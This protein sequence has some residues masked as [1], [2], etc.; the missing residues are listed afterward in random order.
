MPEAQLALAQATD[1]SGDRTEVERGDHA[2]SARRWRRPGGQG[3]S[4]ARRTAGRPLLRGPRNSATRMAT[5]IRTTTG[6]VCAPA[7]SARRVGRRRLL[8]ADHLRGRTRDLRPAGQ[9]AGDHPQEALTANLDP[10]SRRTFSQH[11]RSRSLTPSSAQAAAALGIVYGL[12]TARLRSRW[13][14]RSCPP[15]EATPGAD[16][17]F[18][19]HVMLSRRRR[20]LSLHRANALRPRFAPRQNSA[21]EELRS[22][23]GLDVLVVAL[24][25]DRSA[26]DFEPVAVAGERRSEVARLSDRRREPCVTEI[27]LPRTT[28]DYVVARKIVT[29]LSPGVTLVEGFSCG[30]ADVG[31]NATEAAF[32]SS[33][34][35]VLLLL[36]RRWL[37][38]R[39]ALAL[40]AV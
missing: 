33:R 25:F 5:C 9:A 32:V 20:P 34:I 21:G 28:A 2:R 38:R 16:S 27:V 31:V 36:G 7:V 15:S 40:I 18:G 24:E 8:P 23:T 3:R 19:Q 6:M 1:P 29:L 37:A 10:T 39:A 14:R 13:H 26:G 4:G 12:C 35:S 17:L 11:A 22:W 30:D